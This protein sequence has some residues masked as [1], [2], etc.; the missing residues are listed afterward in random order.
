MSVHAPILVIAIP[1]LGGFAVP[2]LARIHRTVRDLWVVLIAC[3][4]AAGV[5]YVAAQVFSQGIWVYVLGAKTPQETRVSAG[6]PIRIM[7]TVD[8]MSAF[9]G[10]IAGILALAAF[11]FAVRFIPEEEGKTLALA[12]GLL[13]LAGIAGMAYTGDLF[14][15]FVFLEV[16]S[17]AACGLIGFRTWTSRAPEAAFKTM[18]LYSVS[19]LLFLLGIAFLYGEYGAL[20]LAYI[21]AQLR[22]SMVDRIALAL[23]LSGLLMKVAAAP[24][25]FWAP[26]AYGEA[27]AAKTLLLV[28]N[29]QVSLYGLWRILFTLYGGKLDAGVGWLVISM[30]LL[31]MAVAALM[32]IG[33]TDLGRLVAYGAVSQIGYMLLGV[34]VGLVSLTSRAD[35]G[36]V[37]MKG[38]IFHMLNDALTVGL[39]FL[40]VGAVEW[41]KGTRDL[42]ELGGL[43]H[44][45]PAVA[46][47][48]LLASLALAGIPPLNGFASKIMIYEG[49]FRLSPILTALAVLAS[50]LLLAVFARAFQGVFLGPRTEITGRIHWVFLFSMG[51]LAVGIMVLGLVPGFFVEQVVAPAAEALWRGRALYLAAILGG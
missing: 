51:V 40:C 39:L 43:G 28:V 24:V 35:Y 46:L 26:D 14:N 7:L 45:L 3:V 6:F 9:M 10:L 38:G 1:L 32:A 2:I 29:T 13:L 31:T 19:G 17:I 4:V 34:G 21:S 49:S 18:L 20:N 42:R 30:G 33:Q 8:A 27:P 12:L 23:F 47:C 37:A 36:L 5:G 16:T 48:F 50:I 41:V 15:F 25:H 44:Q 11:P 22:G